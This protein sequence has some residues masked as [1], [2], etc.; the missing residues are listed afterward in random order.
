MECGKAISGSPKFCSECGTQVVGFKLSDQPHVPIAEINITELISKHFELLG[1]YGTS[2]ED[3]FLI[4]KAAWDLLDDFTFRVD[5]SHVVVDNSITITNT[6]AEVVPFFLRSLVD[7]KSVPESVMPII[8]TFILKEIIKHD[9]KVNARDFHKLIQNSLKDHLSDANLYVFG[10]TF[11]IERVRFF[12]KELFPEGIGEF[13]QNLL[14]NMENSNPGKIEYLSNWMVIE[15]LFDGGDRKQEW[16]SIYLLNNEKFYPK[17]ETVKHVL[18]SESWLN[19]YKPHLE[20]NYLSHMLE[21]QWL[22][23]IQCR[24]SAGENKSPNDGAEKLIFFTSNGV[25]EIF[26][27]T[28][29]MS[30]ARSKPDYIK[31]QNVARI[32]VGT[33]IHETHAGFGSSAA[34]WMTLTI[35]TT[36]HRINT[37]YIYLG[38][39]EKQMN[40]N[41]PKIMAN[42][43]SISKQY[44]LEAG[45]TVQSSSGFTITPSI[46]F[47]HSI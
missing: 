2:P 13:L 38:D 31:R 7:S 18:E 43:D 17:T 32:T 27:D 41:R 25:C 4:E 26:K 11:Y 35:E 1:G 6:L 20:E 36:G 28:T 30:K 45:S 23:L 34:T 22:G 33:K 8:S 16:R 21:E 14:R 12:Y 24:E 40:E 3:R 46:G 44:C 39:S 19:K 29:F 10:I 37:K 42:L 5:G 47:W 15:N 9:F